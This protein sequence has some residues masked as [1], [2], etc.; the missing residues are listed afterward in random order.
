MKVFRSIF[1]GLLLCGYLGI[2]NGYV[3]L[4]EDSR[5]VKIYPYKAENY[6]PVDQ[7]A[8]KKGIPYGTALEKQRILEDYLS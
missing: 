8:L 2:H 6:S 5:A 7:A 1:L 3:A 4:F